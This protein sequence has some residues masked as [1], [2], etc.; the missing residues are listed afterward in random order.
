MGPP[1]PPGPPGRCGSPGGTAGART[2]TGP[3]ERA[4]YNRPMRA[5]LSFASTLVLLAL[6]S[7]PTWAQ[8]PGQNGPQSAAPGSAQQATPDAEPARL[9]QRTQRIRVEDGGSRVDELRV[10]GQTQN[11]TVQPKTG[12]LPAYEVQSSD[13]ARGRSGSLNGAETSTAPRVWNVMKF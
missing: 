11:I 9:H 2:V 7:A 5:A 13:G 1:G 4:A 10:G 12:D 6:A 8:T 3:A